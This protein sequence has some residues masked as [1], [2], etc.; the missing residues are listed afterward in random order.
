MKYKY[1]ILP[2]EEAISNAEKKRAK[3]KGQSS[4]AVMSSIIAS[5]NRCYA[6]GIE[7]YV[8]KSFDSSQVYNYYNR[9]NNIIGSESISIK[10]GDNYRDRLYTYGFT[11]K[12]IPD[13]EVDLI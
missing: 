10:T 13:I 8:G 11:V 1:I 12:V 2:L 7:N 3:L 6:E 9:S 4:I 5:I